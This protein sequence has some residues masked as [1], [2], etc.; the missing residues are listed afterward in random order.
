MVL[1]WLPTYTAS[2]LGSI[3]VATKTVG[4]THERA[5]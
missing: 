4:V 1:L 5:H 2:M 3:D